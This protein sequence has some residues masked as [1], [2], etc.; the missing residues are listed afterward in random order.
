MTKYKTPFLWQVQQQQEA[1]ERTIKNG[2]FKPFAELTVTP[3][4]LPRVSSF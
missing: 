1:V 2:S 3:K 4:S